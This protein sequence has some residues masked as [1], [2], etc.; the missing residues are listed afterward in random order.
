MESDILEI[1]SIWDSHAEKIAFEILTEKINETDYQISK[2]VSLKE[3]FKSY[4]KEP[5]MEWHI[6][7]LIEDMKGYPVLG[8]EMNGIKHW[9]DPK[10]RKKDKD[11]KILF[12]EAGI[13]LVCIPLPE[14]P[15]YTKEE[16]K[17]EYP[18]VLQ[19]LMDK[20]LMPFQ[21]KTSYPAYCRVCGKQ[22]AY[23]F[24]K[25]YTAA[26]YSCLNKN[27]ECRTISNEKIPFIFKC[28]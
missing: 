11:K 23:V 22:M 21:Y 26:F 20:Y 5:W 24:R 19:D 27:C 10:C 6:D 1:A 15:S 4:Q 8:I 12:T 16:Y 3:I 9:N 17:A 2:H 13:P 14:L 28:N 7:F 25:D 18:K